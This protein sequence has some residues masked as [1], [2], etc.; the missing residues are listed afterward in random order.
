M[1][2]TSQLSLLRGDHHK[3]PKASKGHT[4][5]VAAASIAGAVL[6]D[7]A[8]AAPAMEP[9]QALAAFGVPGPLQLGA[10]AA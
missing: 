6:E 8:V 2:P 9:A 3:S 5:E 7:V 1:F 10:D 4:R